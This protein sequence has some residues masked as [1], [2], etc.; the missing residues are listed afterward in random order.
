MNKKFTALMVVLLAIVF[1]ASLTLAACDKKD[2]HTFAD[3]WSNDETYHWHKCTIAEHTDIADKAEH[4]FVEEG[5]NR[6]CSTCGYFVPFTEEENALYW[7]AA[8]NATL[9]YKDGSTTERIKEITKNGSVSYKEVDSEMWD[10]GSNYLYTLLTYEPIGDGLVKIDDYT[11]VLRPVMDGNTQRFK[12][13]TKSISFDEEKSAYD[14]SVDGTYVSPKYVD[15]NHARLFPLEMLDGYGVLEGNTYAELVADIKAYFEEDGGTV[16]IS[17]VRNDDASVTL[18]IVTEMKGQEKVE[19][20]VCDFEWHGAFALTARDGKI[21]ELVDDTSEI[22]DYPDAPDKKSVEN[23]T[24][25]CSF[26]YTFDQKKID[27]VDITTDETENQYYSDYHIISLDYNYS[28]GFYSSALVGE[29]MLAGDIVDCFR[30]QTSDFVDVAEGEVF[31]ELYTDKEYTKPLTD[32]IATE[33]KYEFYVKFVA[34]EGRALVIT[35]FRR[36][37]N[38]G[39]TRDVFH[40]GYLLDVGERFFPDYYFRSRAILSIEGNTP[41]ELTSFVCNESRIYVVVYSNTS[42]EE[43]EMTHDKAVKEWSYNEQGHW[44]VCDDCG[45]RQLEK[46]AH[47]YETIDGKQTCKVCGYSTTE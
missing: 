41:G 44:H 29:Q 43:R 27:A 24:V 34:P 16:A 1:V 18:N 30:G 3:K 32:Y 6:K 17:F 37:D 45:D 40:I 12:H 23:T 33:E 38:D 15:E 31:F 46:S 36:Q 25:Q 7:I 20:V 19:G 42:G 4:S 5:T 10:F 39:S 26:S 28:W 14:T 9:Q 47:D 21:A 11:E 35:M 22:Y 2:A 8:R 13:F